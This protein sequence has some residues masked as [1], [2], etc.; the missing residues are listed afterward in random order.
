MIDK[1]ILNYQKD[2][3]DKRDFSF[4]ASVGPEEDFMKAVYTAPGVVDHTKAMTPVKN[5]GSLGSCVGFSV[6]AM[7]EWQ[8]TREHLS[9]VSM[10]KKDHRKGKVYDLSEAWLYW[11][12]KKIDGIPNVEGTYIRSAMR[13]L[14]KIGVPCESAWPYNDKIK[15]EPEHWGKLVAIW[16]L[17]DSYWRVSTVEEMKV[18]LIN[19]PVVLGIPCFDTIFY[20][21]ETGLI[22]YPRDPNKIYGGHALCAVGYNNSLYGGSIKVKNSW[23]KYWGKGGYGFIPYAY[24]RDFLWD[25][26]ASKDLSVTNEM[27]KGTREL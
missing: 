26:W 8:E 27:L 14:Q 3:E 21:D 1:K 11:N 17:I 10:G 22:A 2:P 19:G 23:G 25:A 15:G 18:A 16:A 6:T 9:E 5:Q 12:C 4:K 20:A 24:I 13:V 7:K